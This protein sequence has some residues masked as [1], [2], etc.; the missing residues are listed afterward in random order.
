MKGQNAYKRL[1]RSCIRITITGRHGGGITRFG[2]IPD[3]PAEF[4][5][6]Y[7][8]SDTFDDPT[9]KP[10]PLAFL[11]QF[12]CREFAGFDGEGL[13]PHTGVLSFF[14]CAEAA[15]WGFDPQDK[16]CS[17]VYWFS[18]A[19]TLSP[20]KPPKSL[21][22]GDLIPEIGV[23]FSHEESYPDLADLPEDVDADDYAEFFGAIGRDAPVYKLL[24]WPDVIQ[25][26]MAAECELV[27]RGYDLGSSWDGIP[28]EEIRKIKENV[29]EE[30]RLLFQFD[31]IEQ[32]EFELM[33]GDC[34]KLYFWIRK[35]DLLARRFDRVW[36]ILQCY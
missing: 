30:W 3:V 12:D 27:R 25:G 28:R 22:R 34:G 9:V 29:N 21:P 5:W 32:G 10:R 13:L 36:L 1:M 7:F 14:Y 24:G 19:A 2:G 8:E 33:F 17:R 18:D 23:S 6:P 31:S 16:D 15:R 11:A 26:E 4:E 20:A 35:E